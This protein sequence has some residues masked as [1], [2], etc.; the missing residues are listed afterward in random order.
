M[1]F[2]AQRCLVQRAL[3]AAVMLT[4]A[5]IAL[6]T[7]VI[8]AAAAPAAPV[9]E[10]T[11]ELAASRAAKAQ[12]KPVTVAVRTTESTEV[13]ANPDGS[14]THVE[15]LQPVRAKRGDNWVPI[16]LNLRKRA[17]GLIEPAA[18]AVDV[19]LSGGGS[20][21]LAVLGRDSREVGLG[22]EGALPAPVL[23]GTTATY[24]EVLPGV[25]LIVR[26]TITGFSQL[27]VVKNAEAARN[28][29]VR[30]V[31]FNSHTKNV[32]L[33][34]APAAR[35]AGA[36]QSGA[37]LHAVDA[38]GKLVFTGEAS[39]M[40][41]SSGTGAP[42]DLLAGPGA[43]GREASMGVELSGAK[44]AVIPDAGFL[45]AA[46]TRFP[47]YIDPEY[48]RTSTKAHHAVVQSGHQTAKNYDRTDGQLGDLKA[49]YSIEQSPRMASRS[50]VEM[51][52][53]WA[54]GK[55]IHGAD[56]IGRVIH[57]YKCGGGPTQLW[58]TSGINPNTTWLNQ[59]GWNRRLDDITQSA[60]PGCPSDGQ[61][62]I[63]ATGP[64]R[65]GVAERWGNVTFGLRAGDEGDLGSWR[66]FDLNARLEIRYNTPP[67]A[68][69]ELGMEGGLIP[70][71]RGPNR[72]VVFTKTPRLRARL[73]D[74]DSGAVLDA[75]FRVL[76]GTPEQHTWDG[77]ETKIG[78]VPS[79]DFAEVKVPEGVITDGQ[80]HTWHLWAG[81][82][83]ASAWSEMCEFT[84]DTERP[85][86]PAVSSADYPAGQVSG[87]AGQTG[88]FEITAN[89]TP[90]V[91]YYLYSFTDQNTQTPSYRANANGIGGN[92]VVHWTPTMELRQ[93]MRVQA[94]D[95]ANNRSDIHEYSF[96]VK[97][98]A[99]AA[100]GLQ[101]HWRLDTDLSDS[102]GNNRSL[103]PEGA[104]AQQSEG[105]R[106][107]ASRFDGVDDRML[108]R[109]PVL[110][111][112][113]SFTVSAWVKL[114]R[115]NG[116]FT[117]ASQESTEPNH[118][119]SSFFLQYADE[120]DRW[121]FAMPNKSDPS[122]GTARALSSAAPQLGVWTHLVGVHDAA[123]GKL[124]LYVNGIRQQEASVTGWSG[125]GDLVIGAAKWEGR[126][127][128][129]F[130]GTVDEIRVYNRVLQPNEAAF[131]AN[132]PIPRT[133]LVL[134]EGTG[135]T[136]RDAVT[137]RDAQLHGGTA[138]QTG[139]HTAV[140]FN[141]EH[142]PSGGHLVAPR[143]DFRTDQSY[144]VSAWVR[145]EEIA[146]R[147]QTV[148][149][150]G[151]PRYSPFLL[152][153]RPEQR[154]WGFLVSC[155]PNRPCGG[156]ALSA[157]EA[158]PGEWV[159]L[160]GVYDAVARQAR[161]YVDGVRAGV[162][163]NVTGW[164]GAGDLLVGR[165]QWDGQPTDYFNGAVDEVKVFAG[166]PSD[167]EISQ[168][169]IRS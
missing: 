108:H 146:N 167:A 91:E 30:K 66:R 22:W 53:D 18:S 122:G 112:S 115:D 111:T 97:S 68:P 106:G 1:R 64:V 71:V 34:L 88:R 133:H 24:R 29:R 14:F 13:V 156:T 85:G 89:G 116:W 16:D 157:A 28:P 149:S 20:Q 4:A 168:L 25:D 162:E 142:G 23:A 164:H 87:G 165:A 49:G 153:Y 135:A 32:T 145:A 118:Q 51:P 69:A 84:V 26:A 74:P 59:P 76:K 123:G 6:S 126:L 159:H 121:A 110:D 129:Y 65:D 127:V 98:H 35:G 148:V 99:V 102:S 132:Q 169:A 77:N 96:F 3:S 93:T 130:P 9:R 95:R 58:V 55:I 131:L 90:D 50:F 8:P 61:V 31:V 33:G 105:Y 43:G 2:G 57:S 92:A 136:T 158:K 150:A 41:D 78:N 152:Q 44:L 75:G 12:N 119:V 117:V 109:G 125:A 37:D 40:W 154:R 42:A 45:T 107:K 39:R 134:D 19:R 48:Q 79:G 17:D 63:N 11:A 94:V 160:T 67:N 36:D 100:A 47:V 124:L 104:P 54:H 80:V 38:E 81:D 114:D 5:A 21:A 27:L 103:A 141:G 72:P 137:G 144:T 120:P 60:Y 155:D 138:W 128:D 15:H 46:E 10:A 139:E 161:L 52:I 143:P 83:E 70:C 101:A 7:V 62:R 113:K 73:S 147:A 86:K 140:R 151:D 82:Y 166:V 56:F 163:Q